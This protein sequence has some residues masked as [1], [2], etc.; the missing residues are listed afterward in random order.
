[1]QYTVNLNLKKP[2]LTDYVDIRHLNDN[3]DS[4]DTAVHNKVDKITGK[5]LSTEDYTTTEKNKLSGI[6]AG[7]TADQ[8]AA[9]ILTAIKTVDGPSS[10]LDADL[11]DGNHA[12]A[13]A[14][15][16]HAHTTFDRASAV[17]SGANVFS[18][19]VVT[20]GITTAI[21]TRAMTKAD[22]SLGSVENYGIA[23][24]AEAEAGTSELMQEMELTQ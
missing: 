19:I 12:S 16:G 1:M 4:L 20:D 10:G 8:T 13:F 23:T 3:F 21:A 18:D 5:G 22:L 2:D 7:A 14:L 11:L 9:E 15:T 17:L 24:Q 6:E